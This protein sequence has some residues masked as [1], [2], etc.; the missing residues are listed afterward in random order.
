MVSVRT[1]D[2]R[3]KRYTEDI[4]NAS[5][6]VYRGYI[7]GIGIRDIDTKDGFIWYNII[8]PEAIL[9]IKERYPGIVEIL[10]V[11]IGEDWEDYYLRFNH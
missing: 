7:S 4:T 5:L 6:T 11:A 10:N 1:I 3:T 8:E 9:I 2:E